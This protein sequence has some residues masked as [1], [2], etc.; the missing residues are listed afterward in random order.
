MQ[1]EMNVSCDA[2]GQGGSDKSKY[3]TMSV[4]NNNREM[5]ETTCL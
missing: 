3:K 5:W 1:I 4:G 2:N